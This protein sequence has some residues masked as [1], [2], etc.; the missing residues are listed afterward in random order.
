MQ[1]KRALLH[2]IT[3]WLKEAAQVNGSQD[4]SEFATTCW[5]KLGLDYQSSSQ[6]FAP[7]EI[8]RGWS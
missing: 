7:A 8:E 2:A 3:L 6:H 4:P 5:A 1:N